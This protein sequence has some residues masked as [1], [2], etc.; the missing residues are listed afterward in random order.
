VLSST[1]VGEA[2]KIQLRK[3][4]E[5]LDPV[6]I[7]KDM[8]R[9][10]DRFWEYAHKKCSPTT[11]IVS[12][13]DLIAKDSGPP[14]PAVK[15]L[16]ASEEKSPGITET[17]RMYRRTKKPS[18]PRT[19]R[20]RID[21]FADVWRQI[22]LQLEI[23]PSHTAKELLLDLQQR[24]PGKYP[25]GQLRTL[26]RRVRQHRREQLYLNPGILNQPDSTTPRIGEQLRQPLIAGME[27]GTDDRPSPNSG[28]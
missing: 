15:R 28:S 17:V 5:S 8:E 25:R 2:P 24:Y 1:A 11:G 10:Q 9:L 4:Y 23:N 14:K 27:G 19:W 18:V 13:S 16:S 20:T 12:A 6:A 26:Q 3:L 22:C 21:P 7:L